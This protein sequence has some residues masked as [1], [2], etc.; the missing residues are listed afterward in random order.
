[1]PYLFTCTHCQTKTLVDD[2]FSGQTGRCV[3]CGADIRLPDFAPQ[4][5]PTTKASRTGSGLLVGQARPL[6]R[7]LAAATVCMVLVVCGVVAFMRY[8]A[9]A[10]SNL[11]AKRERAD[12]IRN[13]QRIAAALNAYA[14]DHGIYPPPQI[15]AAD[16]KPMHSWRVLILPY[17]GQQSLFNEYDLDQPWDSPKN[18]S[19]VDRMPAVYRGTRGSF[20]GTDTAYY[21]ITGPGTLFPP[22]PPGNP[23]L[24]FRSLGPK[25][26]IDNPGQT[27]LVVEA[28]P[29]T[30]A[31]LVWTQP[32]DLDIGQMRG[33]IGGSPG[34]EI[35]GV[36]N[37]G[38]TVATVDGRGHFV[39]EAT[40]PQT[41]MALVTIA[42]GE[43]LADDVLDQ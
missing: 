5:S 6:V 27:L 15:Q 1:M 19:I 18:Y 20:F 42:G 41:V 30:N 29:P 28:A 34:L 13:I 11:Q 17:L 33:M 8:G 2:R 35:G 7:R 9:P 32:I 24:A 43:P 21:L 36:T 3:T 38:A 25:D 16:G 12:A 37:G 4:S 22:A 14:A 10:I 26:V 39:D 23:E 31:M 40:S